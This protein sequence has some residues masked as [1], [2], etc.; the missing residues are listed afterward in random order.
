MKNKIYNLFQ[1]NDK[2]KTNKN[3]RT[4]T[5]KEIFPKQIAV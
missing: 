3:F 2:I 5:N 4:E 1:S